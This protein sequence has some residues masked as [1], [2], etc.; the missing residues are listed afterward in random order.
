M[1]STFWRHL[2]KCTLYYQFCKGFIIVCISL[3]IYDRV[4]LKSNSQSIWLS[5]KFNYYSLSPFPSLLV[6]DKD[7]LLSFVAQI[8][9]LFELISSLQDARELW[10]EAV[11]LTKRYGHHDDRCAIGRNV[12]ARSQ[13]EDEVCEG[14]QAKQVDCQVEQ[15]NLASICL[16]VRIKHNISRRFKSVLM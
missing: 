11:Y 9:E 10:K 14:Q 15:M 3:S 12:L 13:I 6:T 4:T 8:T 16:P 1:C 2:L 7:L 5:F